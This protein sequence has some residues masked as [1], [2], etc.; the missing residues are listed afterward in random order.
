MFSEQ[1]KI[2]A[3]RLDSGSLVAASVTHARHE[4]RCASAFSPMAGYRCSE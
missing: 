2:A 3:R 1:N 4:Q